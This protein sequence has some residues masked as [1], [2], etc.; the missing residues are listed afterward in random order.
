MNILFIQ[1]QNDTLRRLPSPPYALMYLA[2]I[3]QDLKHNV[4][5]H[6]RNIEIR[7]K[8][9]INS[10]KPDLVAVTSLTGPMLLDLVKVIRFIK[11]FYPAVKIIMGGIHAS[12]LPEQTLKEEEIDFLVIGEGEETFKEFLIEYLGNK[13]Y[14]KVKGLGYKKYGN[15]VINMKRPAMEIDKVPLVPWHLIKYKSYLKYEVLFLTSRG[16][17]HR[18]SFC[19]NENYNF[20][21]WRGMSVER[22]FEEIKHVEKFHPIRRYKFDDDNFTVDRKRFFKILENIPKNSF[23]YFETR[24]DYIDEE[25]CR[26]V[27][28]F[29]DV[30]IFIGIES[31]DQNML[32]CHKK[33]LTIEQIT[34]A[35]RLLH[36]Y[37]IKTAA[38]FIV[39]SPGET[40]EQIN[41]T[42]AFANMLKPMSCTF[43]IFTPFP[44][45]KYY[46]EIAKD[47]SLPRNLEE[48]G[49]FSSYE[50]AYAKYSKASQKF[51]R[52]VCKRYFWKSM[53]NY[54]NK[55]QFIWIF[56]G[57]E[58]LFQVYIKKV[59]RR[60]IG[61][62]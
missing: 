50:I 16:C 10:F 3:A 27:S 56:A 57:I 5:I 24:V 2:S 4:C 6:D 39:G 20:R 42:I 26:K 45:S 28:E 15:I 44:G 48:W 32:D 22:V 11:K 30:I 55:L 52:K 36:K 12:L 35:F 17:P 37:K 33:D 60:I 41:K 58:K 18:C 29:R 54:I 14:E 31:G 47:A 23:I 19:Y 9:I 53:I 1:P 51:L 43:C 13:N 59:I 25:W 34:E 8:K 7:T 61:E 62:L 38:S 40:L 46:D 21:K 49:K